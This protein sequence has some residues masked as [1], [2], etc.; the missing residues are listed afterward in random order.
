M[1]GRYHVGSIV[2]L[3]LDG[4]VAP[5]LQMR[6]SHWN[7]PVIKLDSILEHLALHRHLMIIKINRSYPLY[8]NSHFQQMLRLF[9]F[10]LILK[11]LTKKDKSR[12]PWSLHPSRHRDVLR[13][14]QDS[15]LSFDFPI[16]MTLSAA[17]ENTTPQSWVDFLAGILAAF[18]M[19]GRAR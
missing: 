3:D 14:L 8:I 10:I 2:T 13:L 5:C 12:K 16:S 7:M 17:P 6:M 15:D 9:A 4:R 11:M 1:L 19:D 18:Q